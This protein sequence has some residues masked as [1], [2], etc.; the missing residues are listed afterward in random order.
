MVLGEAAPIPAFFP[1]YAHP[2]NLQL[3]RCTADQRPFTPALLL[4]M[5]KIGQICQVLGLPLDKVI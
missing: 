4:H 3:A 5:P 1:F 2:R